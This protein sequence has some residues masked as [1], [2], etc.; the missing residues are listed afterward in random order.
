MIFVP[1]PRLVFPTR[2]PLFWLQR[3]SR[4]CSTPRGL[5]LPSLRGLRP[6]LRVRRQEHLLRSTSGSDGG[7]FGREGSVR[8]GP[9]RALRYAVS[10]RCHR[11]RPEDLARVCLG[12]LPCEGDPG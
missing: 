7:R 12:H 2:A 10:T 5:Y 9:S 1:L 4:L 6:T 8:E 11:E 3:T